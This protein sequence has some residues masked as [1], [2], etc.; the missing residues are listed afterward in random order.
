MNEYRE[1]LRLLIISG[2]TPLRKDEKKNIKGFENIAIHTNAIIIINNGRGTVTEYFLWV[3]K[4]TE[5]VS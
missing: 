1:T 5:D 4:S 2:L 3:G